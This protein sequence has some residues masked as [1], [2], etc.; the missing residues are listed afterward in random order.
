MIPQINLRNILLCLCYWLFI[1]I[2]DIIHCRSQSWSRWYLLSVAAEPK[3]SFSNLEQEKDDAEE[4]PAN[5]E[6]HEASKAWCQVP[7]V[8]GI[9][10]ILSGKTWCLDIKI[11]WGRPISAPVSFLSG[12]LNNFISPDGRRRINSISIITLQ[13]IINYEI[14][15]LTVHFGI[16]PVI[17]C[18]CIHLAWRAV[19]RWSLYL[20]GWRQ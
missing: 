10:L 9:K 3:H 2:A 6:S 5:E 4:A 8:I 13:M 18:S 11:K 15:Y 12:L 14:L 19:V 1:S 7:D 20:C 17:L 16:Q